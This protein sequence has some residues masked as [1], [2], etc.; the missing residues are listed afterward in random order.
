[1]PAIKCANGK[2]KWGERGACVYMTKQAAERAGR[3]IEAKSTY[4]RKP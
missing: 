1:M 4:K 2:W 3:A